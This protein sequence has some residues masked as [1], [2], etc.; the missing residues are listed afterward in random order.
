[1]I[2][3]I[4]IKSFGPIADVKCKNLSGINL[5]IGHNGS[6]KT[7]FLKSLYATLKTIEQYQRG[8]EPRTYKDLLSE[9]LYWTFQANS[10]GVLVKKNEEN[11]EFSMES[12]KGE[13]F[14]YSFGNS[15]TKSIQNVTD[16]FVATEVNNVFI[17]AK[18][19]VSIQDVI[20]R[21]FDIDKAFGFD[22]S[23]VDLSRALSKTIQGR[24]Y[25]EFSEARKQLN[26][27]VG[28]RIE[29]DEDRKAWLFRDKE[30]RVFEINITSEGIKRLAILDLLLGNH[31]LTRDSV[32]IIDEAEANLHP[33]MIRHFMEILVVL[34]KAGLQIFISTHSYFVI[35]NLYVLAHK[36]NMSIPTISFVGGKAE[37]NDLLYGMPENP[38]IQESIN[39][40]K[41]EITL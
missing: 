15:T 18:E 31:Y 41:E 26:E 19:I 14:C 1:M 30:R 3:D 33:E 24:N 6:G 25:K 21:S 8:K 22:K 4:H 29:Y 36:N 7:F 20:L 35:K 27:A 17:P 13:R 38:I 12:D 5:L 2:R 16:T 32:V 37:Q 10:L 39:I 40:Y 28:G 11:M 23:Y 9:S 34:A